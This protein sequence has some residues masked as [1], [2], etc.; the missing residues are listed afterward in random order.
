MN[1]GRVKKRQ[2][3]TRQAARMMKRMLIHFRG[4]LDEQLKP[5]GVTTAR[6][7][8]LKMIHERPGA[9]GAQLA[10]ICYVTPQSAQALLKGLEVDGWIT[11]VKD[12][13]NERILVAE[14]TESGE[15]L[16]ETAEVLTKTVEK[17][18]WQGVSLEEV[19]TLNAILTRCMG[20]LE[21]E[22]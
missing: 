14:L 15:K 16:L 21:A 3:E 18:V 12:R 7:H 6:L 20:N 19:E 10:R 22:G 1:N 8:L 5:E 4:Q 11:R 9:S 2:E 13:E 17:K